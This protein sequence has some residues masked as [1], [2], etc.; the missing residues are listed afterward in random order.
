MI[1]SFIMSNSMFKRSLAKTNVFIPI[2]RVVCRTSFKFK[3]MSLLMDLLG[4]RE[5]IEIFVYSSEI[6]GK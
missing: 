6:S 4:M 1:N 3:Y 5:L 2:Q